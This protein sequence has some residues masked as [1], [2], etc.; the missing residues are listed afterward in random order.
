MRGFQTREI[1]HMVEIANTILDKRHRISKDLEMR[2]CG[3]KSK[4]DQRFASARVQRAGRRRVQSTPGVET[5]FKSQTASLV[6]LRSRER[7]Q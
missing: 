5:R 2:T 7:I 6:G 3:G 4:N 1:K